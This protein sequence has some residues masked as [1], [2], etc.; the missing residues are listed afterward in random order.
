M[1]ETD[2]ASSILE[3][4]VSPRVACPGD[5][6]HLR[7]DCQRFRMRREGIRAPVSFAFAPLRG[8]VCT[9]YLAPERGAG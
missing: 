6:C 4:D 9:H 5:E 2:V 3:R 7:D 8:G 1:S